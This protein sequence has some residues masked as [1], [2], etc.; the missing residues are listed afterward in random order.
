MGRS[1][2]RQH[3]A[4]LRRGHLSVHPCPRR[5]AE[6]LPDAAPVPRLPRGS[7]PGAANQPALLGCLRW[8][9]EAQQ[10]GPS[11]GFCRHL[12]AGQPK[13]GLVHRGA[14]WRDWLALSVAYLRHVMLPVGQRGPTG[15][16]HVREVPVFWRRATQRFRWPGREGPR[17]LGV[18]VSC[19]PV[20]LPVCH[21]VL[22]VCVPRFNLV[23]QGRCRWSH[24][25]PPKARRWKPVTSCVSGAPGRAPGKARWKTPSRLQRGWQ[26]SPQRP[27]PSRN[28]SPP[29][30]T[31]VP[32][33]WP[34]RGVPRTRSVISFTGEPLCL[35]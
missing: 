12:E 34:A 9:Q 15:L 18:R 22:K 24:T 13:P 16:S 8:W 25:R 26:G 17:L 23:R 10:E 32:V 14:S 33:P 29:T 1:R 28:A 19:F 3:R 7:F 27:A 5:L 6:S 2:P 20:L 30:A 4:F 35:T 21:T 11:P 31:L